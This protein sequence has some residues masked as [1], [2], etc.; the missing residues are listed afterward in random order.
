MA[1]EGGL[2][3]NDKDFEESQAIEKRKSEQSTKRK[4]KENSATR[5][6][7]KLDVHDTAA[8]DLDIL[9]GK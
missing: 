1:E 5:L 4:R 3:V 9:A 2:G 7:S 8:V 6:S